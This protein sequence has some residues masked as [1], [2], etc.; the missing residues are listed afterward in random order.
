MAS[1][2][3]GG[4]PTLPPSERRL[5]R[6]RLE[7]DV[8]WS[9]RLV[10]LAVF[11]AGAC[12][13]AGVGA[14]GLLGAGLREGVLRAVA[15]IAEGEAARVAGAVVLAGERTL[16][17]ALG[18][19]LALVLAAAIVAGVAQVGA[20]FAPPRRA[21]GAG[22]FAAW[23]RR[24][25]SASGVLLDL[26]AVLG[27]LGVLA[28]TLA[29]RAGELL[30]LPGRS[31][32]ELLE[33]SGGVLRA[34]A[35]RSGVLLAGVAGVDLLVRIRARRRRLRM[36]RLEVRREEVEHEG[37]PVRRAERRRRHLELLRER[38]PGAR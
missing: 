5:E 26:A 21:G 33:L 38:G 32:A 28:W 19:V 11:A 6:A 7:G 12:G 2:R 22:A 3:E 14:A 4:E 9:A 17:L 37:D 34:L 8:L 10:G 30:A 1:E 24:G 15:P 16:A 18:P 23:L 36:T 27:L 25:V 31:P 13:V 29:D 20:R 35:V